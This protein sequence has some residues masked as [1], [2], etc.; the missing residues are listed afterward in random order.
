M[1]DPSD[2]HPPLADNDATRLKQ[3]QAQLARMTKVFMDG[4]DPIVIR[5]LNGNVLDL[6][7]ETERV[8][9]YSRGELLGAR[10]R[11]LLAPE[12]RELADDTLARIQRGE[13]V[14]NVEAAVQSKSGKMVP[15]LATV[16]V[17]TDEHGQP[18]GYAEI[19]KDITTLKESCAH[20]QQRNRDLLQFASIL[21]HDLGA[22][23]RGI[24]HFTD[25]VQRDCGDKLDEES[26][27]NLQLVADSARQMDNL[28]T[29]LL[30]YSRIGYR[31]VAFE[32]VDSSAAC[33]QAL[34]HLQAVITENEAEVACGPLPTVHSNRT[35]L[36]QLFQNLIGNAIKFRR[37][38]RPAVQVSAER[39]GSQWRF[40]VRDNG[41]G[42]DETNLE[43]IF[44]VFRR[45]H[46]DNVFP[47][48]GSGLAICKAIVERHGGRIWAESEKGQG[49]VFFFTIPGTGENGPTEGDSA[50]L[51]AG[52]T[53]TRKDD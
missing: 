46:G 40:A 26:Q 51:Q 53:A 24:R 18:A 49:S 23:L 4:A 43:K 27:E 2:S 9:G 22:P 8:F 21:A 1:T 3:I 10:T 48:T 13:T 33:Q 25:Q 39:D 17:L 35:M 45:L 11:H 36:V 50:A 32:P 34:V 7:R 28:I 5:D 20:L 30:E 12:F 44:A 41:I 6:N 29:D 31:E 19:V 52:S 15:V 37:F 14:R 38:D 16:F 47:G 42:I